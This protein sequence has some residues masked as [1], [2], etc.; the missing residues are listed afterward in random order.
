MCHIPCPDHHS[1]IVILSISPIIGILAN[2]TLDTRMPP[3]IKQ[4][5]KKRRVGDSSDSSDSDSD[6]RR[7]TLEPIR[8]RAGDVPGTSGE[9]KLVRLDL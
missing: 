8:K 2:Q 7:Q 1:L 9:F 5:P 3:V 4:L 6:N